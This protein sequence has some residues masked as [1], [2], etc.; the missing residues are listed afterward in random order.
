MAFSNSWVDERG[1][2]VDELSREAW[3]RVISVL[4]GSS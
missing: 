2:L 1:E 4:D 3:G